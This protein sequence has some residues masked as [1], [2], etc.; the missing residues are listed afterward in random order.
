MTLDE[1]KA[2]AVKVLALEPAEGYEHHTFSCRSGGAP[3][4]EIG[5]PEAHREETFAYPTAA[6]GSAYKGSVTVEC[7]ETGV[8]DADERM[9]YETPA[10]QVFVYVFR[11]G[12]PESFDRGRFENPNMAVSGVG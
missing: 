9:I 3:R 2:E 11:G 5:L 1:L 12:S 4:N 8:V 7:R 6:H 10:H